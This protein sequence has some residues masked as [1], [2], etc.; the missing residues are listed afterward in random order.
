MHLYLSVTK[1]FIFIKCDLQWYVCALFVPYHIITITCNLYDVTSRP[2]DVMHYLF[3][4]LFQ[5]M[6]QLCAFAYVNAVC[7]H[8][9]LCHHLTFHH[10]GG[11]E[12]DLIKSRSSG[13]LWDNL[14]SKYWYRII[15]NIINFI[16]D[17]I[18]C[19]IVLR[20]LSK[21]ATNSIY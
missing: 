18:G 5:M 13:I 9:T 16:V 21:I 20:N 2:V 3:M 15:T 17:E 6:Q 4:K 12:K 1:W 8:L 7:I 19:N 10:P 11:L 14:S